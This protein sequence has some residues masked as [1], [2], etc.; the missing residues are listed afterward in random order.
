MSG[1]RIWRLPS[2]GVIAVRGE[3]RQRLTIQLCRKHLTRLKEA[4][5]D[6]REIKGWFYKSGW[7]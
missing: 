4:G 1:A 7:W 3:D 5:P 2:R 6:G